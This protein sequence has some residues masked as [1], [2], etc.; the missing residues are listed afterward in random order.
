VKEGREVSKRSEVAADFIAKAQKVGQLSI[1]T[2]PTQREQQ[3]EGIG[4]L[5]EDVS[6][7]VHLRRGEEHDR[8]KRVQL[9]GVAREHDTLRIR[10][11]IAPFSGAG[12]IRRDDHPPDPRVRRP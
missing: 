1:L 2:E 5:L 6:E 8:Q 11:R 7:L 10:Q 9:K 3:D 12:L 4:K